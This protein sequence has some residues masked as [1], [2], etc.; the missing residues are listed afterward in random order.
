[1]SEIKLKAKDIQR[2]SKLRYLFVTASPVLTSEVRRFYASL[3]EQLINHLRTKEQKYQE[4]LQ[5][6]PKD[7]ESSDDYEITDSAE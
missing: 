2:D 7:N 4:S 1:M 3:K 6:K 5:D